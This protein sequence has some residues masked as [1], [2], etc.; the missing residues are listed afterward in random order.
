MMARRRRSGDAVAFVVCV[1]V[2]VGG[3]V[4]DADAGGVYFRGA[5]LPN[6]C[7]FRNWTGVACA[8]CGLTRSV[9]AGCHLDWRESFAYHPGGPGILALALFHV[10]VGVS[11]FLGRGRCWPRF[12]SGRV[13]RGLLSLIAV[14]ALLRWF[15]CLLS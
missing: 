10:L 8:G 7:S 2:L 5:Q 3:T 13:S 6:V 12:W 11:R 4:L 9:I 1:L 14:G 15:V